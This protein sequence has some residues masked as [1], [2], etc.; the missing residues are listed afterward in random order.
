MLRGARIVAIFLL[1]GV[2]SLLA[3]AAPPPVPRDTLPEKILIDDIPEGLPRPRP[4]PADNPLTYAGVELGR[5]LFFDPIL[6]V[7]RTIACASCHD[8]AHG[9]AGREA[10]ALGVHGKRGSRHAPSLLNRAYATNLFW[11]GR[12]TS[13]E[14]QALRPIEDSHEMGNTMAE[15][16]ARLRAHPDYP[17]RFRAAF[18]DGVTP[19]NL[20]RALASFERT[21]LLGDTPVDRF[22]AGRVGALSAM[23]KHGLWLWESKA[24]CWKCHSGANFTDGQFHNT[25]VSWGREPSDAGRFLVTRREVDRGKFRTPSLRAVAR[26]APY[27]HDGSMASLEEVLEFYN[28]G[29]GKNRNLDSVIAPLGLSPQ[30]MQSLLAFLHALSTRSPPR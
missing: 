5:R 22:R 8:P 24:G 9:F 15:A 16:I 1:A 23:E 7:D 26:T 3:A 27:M 6:S 28:R 10:R 17:A 19:A 4:V 11:D 13:L 2:W 30:E 14:D 12:A 29:G 25:G 21:L 18:D 20:A